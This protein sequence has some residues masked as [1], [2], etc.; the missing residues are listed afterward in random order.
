LQKKI[1]D[2]K[3]ITKEEAENAFLCMH[4]KACED[5]CQTNLEL[6]PLWDAIEKKIEKKFGRPEE[7]IKEFLKKVDENEEYW[8][9]VER[10]S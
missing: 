8:K 10:N 1:L 9:M 4:C 3:T 7:K 2:G 5:V 6:M